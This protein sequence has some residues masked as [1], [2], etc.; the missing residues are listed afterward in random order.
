MMKRNDAGVN[1]RFWPLVDFILRCSCSVL[2]RVLTPRFIQGGVMTESTRLREGGLNYD[3]F[4]VGEIQFNFSSVSSSKN[5]VVFTGL[6]YLQLLRFDQEMFFL[7][8]KTPM[9]D[10]T[11]DLCFSKGVFCS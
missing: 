4:R 3:H 10:T 2:H 11:K 7:L 6:I 5:S 1:F 8:T 9:N